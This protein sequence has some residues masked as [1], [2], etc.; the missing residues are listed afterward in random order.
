MR[1]KSAPHEAHK[2]VGFA[3]RGF[4]SHVPLSYCI[5]H[6]EELDASRGVLGGILG[7]TYHV[8]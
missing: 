1:K 4:D 2:E 6:T 5:D 7:A 8:D 3:V